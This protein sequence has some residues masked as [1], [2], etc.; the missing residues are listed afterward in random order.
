M[1]YKGLRKRARSSKSALIFGTVFTAS[2]F[3]ILTFCASILLSFTKNPL[4]ASGIV[5]FAVLL[6]TGALSGFCTAKYKGDY[7]VLPSSA[8]AIIFALILLGAGLIVSG[9]KIA[10]VSLINLMCFVAL[11]IIFAFLAKS[12]RKR[13]HRR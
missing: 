13:T 7:G 8:S 4:G 3:F 1:K 12:K 9:G 10:T 11:A 6:L 5:S 2:I